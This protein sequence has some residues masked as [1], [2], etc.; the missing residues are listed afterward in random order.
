MCVG[1]VPHMKLPLKLFIYIYMY[2]V[3][4]WWTSPSVRCCA[5]LFLFLKFVVHTFIE[6]D[7]L[8]WIIYIYIFIC[9]HIYIFLNDDVHIEKAKTLLKQYIQKTAWIYLGAAQMIAGRF[10]I[11]FYFNRIHTTHMQIV[12]H[13]VWEACIDLYIFISYI[14]Y[15]DGWQYW[16]VAT[17][18]SIRFYMYIYTQ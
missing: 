18:T 6:R 4:F 15:D 9:T 1:I 13:S 2:D 5:V 14:L 16:T 10:S 7:C 17:A 11:Q 3:W 12:W 8:L